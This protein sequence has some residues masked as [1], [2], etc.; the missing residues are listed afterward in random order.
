MNTQQRRAIQKPTY[1]GFEVLN[2]RF[3]LGKARHSEVLTVNAGYE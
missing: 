3:S 2:T 1:F